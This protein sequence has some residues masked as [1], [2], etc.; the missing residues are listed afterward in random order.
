MP[1]TARPTLT[2]H[3]LRTRYPFGTLVR[4]LRTGQKAMVDAHVHGMLRVKVGSGHARFFWPHEVEV[5]AL[6]IRTDDPAKIVCP[7]CEASGQACGICE[8]A[9]RI[10]T[11]TEN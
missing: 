6:P 10:P 1:R 2:L 3:T 9:G 7:M 4:S 8:G 11:K 5:V